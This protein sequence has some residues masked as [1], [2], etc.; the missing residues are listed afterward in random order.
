ME[1]SSNLS[2]FENILS[3]AE[4]KIK[5]TNI[6]T[7]RIK[8]TKTIQIGSNWESYIKEYRQL[9]KEINDEF[10]K[11]TS[12]INKIDLSFL[13]IATALQGTKSLLFPL[14]AQKVGYG[15]SFDKEARLK[16]NDKSII[17]E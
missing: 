8:R 9:Q 17:D 7:D 10:A 16:E 2:V 1:K 11:K 3:Y 4:K 12:I 6:K 15:E 5:N 13:A 14:V